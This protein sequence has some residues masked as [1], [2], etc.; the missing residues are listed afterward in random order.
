MDHLG[1][2][3]FHTLGGCIGASYCLKLCE[4]ATQRIS[5]A[6]LQNP[7][8]L[9]PEFPTYYQDGSIAWV[10]EH[11]A[12]RPTEFDAATLSSFSHNM[13]DRGFVFSVSRDFA[14]GCTVPTRLLPGSDKPH[15]G[16]DQ[17]G[18]RGRATLG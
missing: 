7:I 2:A 10:A 16:G 8:G 11:R 5:A 17:R 3:R 13:W 1:H 14:R 6:V 18:T 15:P 9:N 12:T 4:I